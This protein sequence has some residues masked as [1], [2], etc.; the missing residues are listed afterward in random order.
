[1]VIASDKN[2]DLAILKIDDVD[3]KG[4]AQPP[5]TFS[6][7]MS[8]VVESVY[9]LGYPLRSTMGGGKLTNGI[10]SSKT[11][12]QGDITSCQISAPIQPGN[13]GG[14]LLNSNGEIVGIVSAKHTQAEKA[15]YAIKTNY[16]KSL[17]SV[18]DEEISISKTNK[19]TSLNLSQQVQLVR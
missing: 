8:L 14:L 2:N 18:V 13:S 6:N 9:C 4:F 19:L 12:Y 7:S 5:Y 1:M 11:G 16:L 10:I 17:V 3:F 15:S